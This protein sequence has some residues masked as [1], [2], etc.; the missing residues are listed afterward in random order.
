MV[1]VWVICVV[2]TETLARIFEVSSLYYAFKTRSVSS[3]FL[4]FNGAIR[5]V[6]INFVVYLSIVIWGIIAFKDA[7]LSI[8]RFQFVIQTYLLAIGIVCVDSYID[9]LIRYF[10]VTRNFKPPAQIIMQKR[11]ASPSPEQRLIDDSN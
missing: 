3:R 5:I 9:P 8:L 1:G 11:Q 4:N 6:S 2:P 7:H 10:L